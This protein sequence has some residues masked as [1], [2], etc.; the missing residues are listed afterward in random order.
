MC[1]FVLIMVIVHL[2]YRGRARRALTP[3]AP[4]KNTVSGGETDTPY[5]PSEVHGCASEVCVIYVGN[6]FGAKPTCD[7]CRENICE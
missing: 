5:T 3:L 7:F 2:R 4:G 6:S 1:V